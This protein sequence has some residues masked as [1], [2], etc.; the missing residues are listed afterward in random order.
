MIDREMIVASS[1]P[2]RP[3]DELASPVAGAAAA[4]SVYAAA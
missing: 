2:E 4:A 3:E 1:T